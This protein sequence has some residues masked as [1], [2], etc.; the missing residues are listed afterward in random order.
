MLSLVAWLALASPE[1]RV[2]VHVSAPGASSKDAAGEP[3]PAA[4]PVR[5]PT[6]YI[7][8]PEDDDWDVIFDCH[9]RP[10]RCP[11]DSRAW[12]FKVRTHFRGEMIR[13]AQGDSRI[14]RP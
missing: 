11:R 2:Q 14:P 8:L 4:A 3:T 5:E 12:L 9:L 7:F 6:V 10:S 13:L 1:V